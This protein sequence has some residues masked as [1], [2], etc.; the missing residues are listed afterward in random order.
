M[1]KILIVSI[2][3]LASACTARQEYY[4]CLAVGAIKKVKVTEYS[5]SSVSETSDYSVVSKADSPCE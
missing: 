5:L 2:A 4:E 3:L 1:K